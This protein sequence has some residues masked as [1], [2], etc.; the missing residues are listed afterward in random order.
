MRPAR[1]LGSLREVGAESDATATP[2]DPR[3]LLLRLVASDESCLEAAL[4]TTSKPAPGVAA[5]LDRKVRALVRLGA[6]LAVGAPT[7][8]LRWAVDVA[9]TAGAD[10]EALVGV[11]ASISGAVGA[12]QIVDA[13]PRLALALGFDTE[14]PDRD[15]P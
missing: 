10:D 14:L 15:E 9:S 7:A 4:V 3:L 6:L 13:A 12:A 1:A 5:A 11:L 8:S 2:P